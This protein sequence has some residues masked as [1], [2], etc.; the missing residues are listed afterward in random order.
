[1]NIIINGENIDAAILDQ[2]FSNIKSQHEQV[3]NV[4]CCERD[5]EFRSLANDNVISRVLLV[6]EARR[7][8]DPVKPADVEEAFKKLMEEHG[9]PDKFRMSFNLGDDEDDKVRKDVEAN[10][11]VQKLLDRT[12]GPGPAP[13]DEVLKA[14]YQK[15]LDRFM[16]AEKVRAS[17]I[18][19]NP[20]RGEDRTKAYDELRGVREKLL[21]GADFEELARKHSDRCKEAKPETEPPD[22]DQDPGD[23]IDLGWFGRGDI[24]EEFELV[25]FSMRVG[26]ISPVFLTSYGFHVVKLAERQPSTPKPFEEVRDAVQEQYVQDLRAGKVDEYV[27]GLRSKA[28]IEEKEEEEEPEESSPAG[29]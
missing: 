5:D 6:Q 15:H 26:E 23:P 19:R 20:P 7:A 25:A 8:T 3:G 21:A 16:T 13:S 24:L 1:M 10:L 28:T 27:K 18:L 11:R 17:H 14:Y 9:G 2:E 4:S 12:C 22:K 29:D